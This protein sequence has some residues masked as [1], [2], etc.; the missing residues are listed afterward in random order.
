M[1]FQ[2]AVQVKPIEHHGRSQPDS[3]QVRP[4]MH[5]EGPALDA[6]VGHRLLAVVAALIHGRNAVALRD[7][8]SPVDRGSEADA[9]RIELNAVLRRCTVI[10]VIS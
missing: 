10:L 1:F 9:E 8:W 4:E 6:Q 5:L 7:R 3:L 2:H